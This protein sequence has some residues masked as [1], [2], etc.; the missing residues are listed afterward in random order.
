MLMPD[1]DR[2]RSTLL[3]PPPC[4]KSPPSDPE[5]HLSSA[6]ERDLRSGWPITSSSPS[7]FSPPSIDS[8]SLPLPPSEESSCQIALA[9]QEEYED[10]DAC[11]YPRRNRPMTHHRTRGTRRVP[12]RGQSIIYRVKRM[13]PGRW[14]WRRCIHR[15]REFFEE[16][17]MYAVQGRALLEDEAC[18]PW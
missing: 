10:R 7:P 3:P 1:G 9:I 15:E 12:L 16:V 13:I 14:A 4:S 5:S 2:C 18:S 6:A 17:W 8:P 11:A